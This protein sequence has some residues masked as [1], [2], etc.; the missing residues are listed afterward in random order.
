MKY[1]IVGF[2]KATGTAEV[3]FT[4]DDYPDGLRLAVDIPIENGAYIEGDAL[5]RHIMAFAPHGQI[6]RLVAAK[7]ADAAVFSAVT[8][9]TAESQA[10]VIAD[11]VLDA[12]NLEASRAAACA[13]ID[14]AANAARGQYIAT[15]IGIQATYIAKYQQAAT[16]RDAE[17]VGDPPPYVKS[18]ADVSGLA[19]EDVAHRICSAYELWTTRID[20]EIEGHRVG[21]KANVARAMSMAHVDT[22]MRKAVAA[23]QGLMQ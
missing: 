10:D 22:E 20:P 13:Q 2:N 23:L 7:S 3:L 1:E 9:K 19:A 14:K 18:E 11:P 5:R 16:W 17:Y 4:R 15:G 8:E 12:E 21:G 6:D